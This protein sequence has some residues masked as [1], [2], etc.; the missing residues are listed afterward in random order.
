VWGERIVL[1]DD[2]LSTGATADACARTLLRAGA[3]E[4]DVLALAT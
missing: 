2:V 1:V 4:V 3:C